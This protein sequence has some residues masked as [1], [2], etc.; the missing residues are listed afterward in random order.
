[1]NIKT[2]YNIGDKVFLIE[3]NRVSENKIFGKKS[4][5]CYYGI[6]GSNFNY[7]E[8]DLFKNPDDLME[9]LF[10]KQPMKTFDF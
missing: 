1:M 9:S 4:T 5:S 6:E 10:Q 2:K 3:N 7:K 8:S